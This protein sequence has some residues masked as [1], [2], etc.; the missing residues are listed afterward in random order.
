[1]GPGMQHSIQSMI[2]EDCA[3][4]NMSQTLTLL[5]VLGISTY[6]CFRFDDNQIVSVVSTALSS[7]PHTST[8]RLDDAALIRRARVSTCSCGTGTRACFAPPPC[9]DPRPLNQHHPM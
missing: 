5:T 6:V 8:R 2:F 1:V 7:H 4:Q 9:L 3:K